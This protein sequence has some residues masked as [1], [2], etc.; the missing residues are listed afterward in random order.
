[1]EAPARRPDRPHAA[2]VHPHGVV[3][4]AGELE[5]VGDEQQLEAARGGRVRGE[6]PVGE[7]GDRV[8]ITEVERVDLD[9]VEAG[10]DPLSAAVGRLDADCDFILIDCP[11]S[12]TRLSQMA[13]ALADTLITPMNDSFVD[14]DMLGH[15]DPVT[16]DLQKPSL[17]SETVWNARKAKMIG[18][19]RSLDWV[20]LRNRLAV[21][22]AKNRKRVEDR[23]ILLAK[24]VG[25]RVGPGLRD[26]VIYRELFPFGLSIADLSRKVRPV[27]MG[28][29]HV[30]ARQE[31]RNLMKAMGLEQ[32]LSDAPL[33]V[34]AACPGLASFSNRRVIC[35]GQIATVPGAAWKTTAVTSNGTY[36]PARPEELRAV[37]R[38]A[39]KLSDRLLLAL[40]AISTA[41]ERIAANVPPL[42]ALEAMCISLE[43]PS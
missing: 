10:E 23:L 34:A 24:R 37:I 15:L 19:R 8:E 11:G 40:D 13:H 39:Y 33:D 31:M 43:L 4:G 30:A 27:E 9:A 21:K 16:L 36:D 22:E 6:E 28:L 12:H 26:R 2:L 3:A 41:R 17:Y 18:E 25:F 32:A 35:N 14:F 42:L 1:M 29:A 5:V 38:G 7:G 20:V